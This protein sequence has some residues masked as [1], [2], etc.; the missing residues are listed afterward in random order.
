MT[1]VRE[2]DQWKIMAPEALAADQ[3]EVGAVLS[4]CA[5]LR[6]QAFLS[7]DAAGVARVPGQARGEA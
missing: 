3:V 7:E 4:R 1:V 2:N 5:E 6:A